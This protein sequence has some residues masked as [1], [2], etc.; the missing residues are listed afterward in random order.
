MV[1]T[2]GYDKQFKIT[3]IAG[4]ERERMFSKRK[5]RRIKLAKLR[6]NIKK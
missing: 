5:N 3:K 1:E 6:K 2:L 4:K